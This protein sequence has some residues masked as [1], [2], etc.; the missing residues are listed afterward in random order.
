MVLQIRWACPLCIEI[1]LVLIGY[2]VDSAPKWVPRGQH[3]L[4]SFLSFHVLSCPCGSSGRLRSMRSFGQ[5][6]VFLGARSGYPH[7]AILRYRCAK[8][9]CCRARRWVVRVMVMPNA[10][11]FRM[12]SLGHTSSV[13]MC[14]V[15]AQCTSGML[16]V[17]VAATSTRLPQWPIRFLSG[18]LGSWGLH[19]E[20]NTLR[21]RA[22]V[23]VY[24]ERLL[25][26]SL[27]TDD[28]IDG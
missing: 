17:V 18:Y 21:K 15:R 1:I 24:E 13:P 12:G 8:F 11:D 22:W 3:R 14:R 9:R 4:N 6:E 28:G 25:H 5:V 2:W 19:T 10:T 27:C 23:G 7:L 20:R 16:G 26:R